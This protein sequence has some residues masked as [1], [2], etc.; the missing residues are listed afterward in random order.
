MFQ[1]LI[2][3]FLRSIS[4]ELSVTCFLSLAI[5]GALRNPSS[6]VLVLISVK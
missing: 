1:D 3:K 2:E 6:C 4:L 5:G